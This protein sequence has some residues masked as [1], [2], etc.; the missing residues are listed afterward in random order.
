MMTQTLTKRFLVTGTAVAGLLALSMPAA[1]SAIKI[2]EV[3]NGQAYS[4]A[5]KIVVTIPSAAQVRQAL[6]DAGYPVTAMPA[7]DI[8]ATSQTLVISSNYGDV[9]RTRG[10][11]AASSWA[12]PLLGDT[13]MPKSS[14]R[15]DSTSCADE[16]SL[17]KTRIALPAPLALGSVDIAGALSRTTGNL[18]TQGNTGIVDVNLNL[19]SLI[20][21]GAPLAAIGEALNTVR[22]S[23]NTSVV[24]AVNSTVATV[25]TTL[26]GISALDPIRK[27][28]DRV[29]TIGQLKPLPDLRTV[30]LVTARVLAGAASLADEPAATLA[31]LRATSLTEIV[32]LGVFGG[33][34]SADSIAVKASAFANGVKGEANAQANSKTDITNLDVGGLLG[35]HVSSEDLARLLDAETLKT[36]G[37]ETLKNLGLGAAVQELENALDLAYNTAGVS[38]EKLANEEKVSPLGILASATANSLRLRIAPALPNYA[39]LTAIGT[40]P[41]SIIPKLAKSDFTPTGLA[42][43]IDLPSATAAVAATSVK[44]VCIGSC[45]PKTG[46]ESKALWALMLIGL[47]LG[48]R[49]FALGR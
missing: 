5:M 29:L 10:T 13:S 46:V 4:E 48:V 44:P 17:A 23:V 27:E 2:P 31:G 37:G 40:T 35:V 12:A 16:A 7:L 15:C 36:A 32:N 18:K 41:G 26:D 9:T 42:I 38:L 49:R 11:G 22:T 25:K 19:D 6:L 45:V 47:A 20:G 1:N 21:A 30:D 33:W 28:V 39:K 3:I 34:V 24:P 43:T 8:G 14:S